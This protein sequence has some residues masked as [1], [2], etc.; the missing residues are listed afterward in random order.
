MK[1]DLCIYLFLYSFNLYLFLSYYFSL[2]KI[3]Q[4]FCLNLI[5]QTVRTLGGGVP[6][7]HIVKWFKAYYFWIAKHISCEVT[8]LSSWAQAAFV[9]ESRGR[10]RLFYVRVVIC[11]LKK[12][13]SPLLL[14]LPKRE[15]VS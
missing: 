8:Q 3:F 5:N 2:L 12:L 10:I 4:G 6:K 15:L 14:F 9:Q 7:R 11:H 1:L 13:E